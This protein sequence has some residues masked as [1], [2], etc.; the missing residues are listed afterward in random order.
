MNKLTMMREAM[1]TARE[2]QQMQREHMDRMRAAMVE[3][4][5]GCVPPMMAEDD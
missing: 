5:Y 1:R 2:A 4:E 3:S